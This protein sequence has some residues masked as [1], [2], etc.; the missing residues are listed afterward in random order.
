M[1]LMLFPPINTH[2]VGGIPTP[3]EKYV[4]VSWDDDIPNW[5]ESHKIPWFQSPPTRI[6]YNH[7]Y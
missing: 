5:I 4:F 6:G 2:L 7:I 3:S 1:I